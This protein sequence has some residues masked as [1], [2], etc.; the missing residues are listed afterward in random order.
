MAVTYHD[1]IRV[2]REAEGQELSTI[3]GRAKFSTLVVG[4]TILVVPTSTM[5]A[6]P[7]GAGTRKALDFYNQTGSMATSDYQ[8]LTQNSSYILRLISLAEGQ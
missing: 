4:D 8:D 2:A 7:L 5:N 1:L 3:G 6:R